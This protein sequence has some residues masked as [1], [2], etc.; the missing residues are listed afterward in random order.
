MKNAKRKGKNEK[1]MKMKAKR[2]DTF[3]ILNFETK[4]VDEFRPLE[5][6]REVSLVVFYRKICLKEGKIWR[7]RFPNKIIITFVTQGLRS[8]SL[9]RPILS[10]ECCFL[11]THMMQINA[12]FTYQKNK[13]KIYQSPKS[14]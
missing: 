9:R 12:I 1:K 6:D 13:S 7:K 3:R 4:R 14:I 8:F 10:P 5:D 11:S 2:G